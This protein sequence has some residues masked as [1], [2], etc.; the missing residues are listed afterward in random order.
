MQKGLPLFFLMSL[1][2]GGCSHSNSTDQ[3]LPLAMNEMPSNKTA[4]ETPSPIKASTDTAVLPFDATPYFQTGVA[5]KALED[6]HAKRYRKAALAFTDLIPA[7]PDLASPLQYMRAVS[8]FYAG[9]HALAASLFEGMIQSYPVLADHHR[10]FGATAYLHNSQPM[11]A[12]DLAGKVD[13]SGANGER[14][15]AT[16]TRAWMNAKKPSKALK[17]VKEHIQQHGNSA[18]SQLL[19][20]RTQAA[21]Q[22][23][24]NAANSYRYLLA[25]WPTSR[26]VNSAKRELA[27]GIKGLPKKRRQAL[28][29]FTAE[30]ELLRGR[31]LFEKHRS[32]EAIEQL[33]AAAKRFPKQSEQR[34][35]ALY[36]TGRSWDKLR[37]RKKG[38]P[39]YEVAFKECGKTSW[40]VKL[41]YFG[42]RSF[43]RQ[44]AHPR[45]LKLFEALHR[46]Y[47][48]HSYNDDALI[49]SA[50]LHESDGNPK[51]RTKVL[52]QI[53]REYP[54]GD[55]REQAAWLLL[56]DV[57]RS[58]D[59]A[60]TLA[61]ADD[62]LELIPRAAYR[63]TK[64]RTLYWKARAL[65]RMG[66]PEKATSVYTT[67]L[68]TYPMSYYALL[69]NARL[70]ELVGSEKA[71][72]I[73]A[74]A[75]EEDDAPQAPIAH[76][77][78][79][80]L[81][82]R[83]AFQRGLELMKIGLPSPAKREFATLA[84]HKSPAEQWALALLYHQA[85]A[86]S[87]SHGIPRRKRTEFR[88][89]YP[90]GAHG[91]RW[92]IAY[93]RPFGNIVKK[94][95][96][97]AGIEE[98]I[99]YS[100][101]RTESAFDPNIESFANAVGLLQLILPTAKRLAQGEP[102]VINRATLKNPDRNV[103]LGT[104]FLGQLQTKFSH[105]AVM[106]AGYNAGQGAA[107][108]WIKKFGHLPLDE[109]VETIP[110]REARRYAK[111]VLN[112]LATY[113][114]LY[115]EE[116]WQVPLTIPTP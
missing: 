70:H 12:I 87:L 10:Y 26:E 25:R 46:L 116:Y 66:H 102:G 7:N 8:Y 108:R 80:D 64:G 77:I 114:L 105:P 50:S 40:Y 22:Q 35:E 84:L 86:A 93:P 76:G 81:M 63:W 24:E 41:L 95:A 104:R 42:G 31:K 69:A 60:K 6:F 89:H 47:P 56:W 65:T 109:F 100:I 74:Q 23:E 85:G 34:C 91:E 90:R 15:S 19:L 52:E 101:M 103:Q 51:D 113:R 72:S 29:R 13:A 57:Y 17:Q 71:E 99:V 106:A 110:Y 27:K 92:K 53:L 73:L 2:I 82:E 59:M 107:G 55:K 18:S 16:L 44:G 112:S 68:K 111:S 58:G 97:V 32:T 30:E 11:K 67:V 45:A 37:K 5:A 21:I 9:E 1:L 4:L 79:T 115:K 94:H 3:T 38:H 75:M 39:T 83:P 88:D 14:A 43:Y 48:D 49:W 61:M 20:A 98:E 33:K 54:E 62:H 28:E 96:K 36:L 78:T